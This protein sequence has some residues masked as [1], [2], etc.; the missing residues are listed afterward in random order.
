MP[1]AIDDMTTAEKA[2]A[3]GLTIAGGLFIAGARAWFARSDAASKL[4]GVTIGVL[5]EKNGEGNIISAADA[6][7]KCNVALGAW[8]TSR[9][10]A[11]AIATKL[12]DEQ[13]SETS[14]AKDEATDQKQK[15]NDAKKQLND[16]K[17]LCNEP[18][19]GCGNA[20]MDRLK[21]L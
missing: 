6:G 8:E 15:A 11:T 12:L 7:A 13:K 14:K 16:V 4:A 21:A 19:S 2:T 10:D 18:G 1:L 17:S 20:V 9:T 3:G 5:G